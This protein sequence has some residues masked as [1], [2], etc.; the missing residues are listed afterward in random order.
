MAVCCHHRCEWRWYCGKSWLEDHEITEQDFQLMVSMAG[1]ATCGS[2]SSAPELRATQEGDDLDVSGNFGNETKNSIL[3]EAGKVSAIKK[4][5]GARILTKV[6]DSSRGT[7]E[8]DAVSKPA[9]ERQ[10]E[11]QQHKCANADQDRPGRYQM[12][13]L[14]PKRRQEIGYMVKA[15]L[16]EGRLSY[17]RSR[18]MTAV[19]VNFIAQT[20]TPENFAIVATARAVP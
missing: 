13:G 14:T 7:A 11:E 18:G 5:D 17:L 4:L 10:K 1:W 12:M 6:D 2:R 8:K 20:Y 19:R 16:D 15:V 9:A 3:V